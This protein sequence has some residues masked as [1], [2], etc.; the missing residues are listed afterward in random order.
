[1]HKEVTSDSSLHE[2]LSAVDSLRAFLALLGFPLHA[3]FFM[4]GS[5]FSLHAVSDGN[6][7]QYAQGMLGLTKGYFL[8]VCYIHVFRMATFFLLT[9]FFARLIYQKYGRKKF[10]LNRLYRIGLP[11]LFFQLWAVCLYFI[12]FSLA[13]FLP[14]F[15]S[16]VVSNYFTQLYVIGGG[17]WGRVNSLN[18]A[19]F[20]YF[21]LWFYA[22]T[23][24]ILRLRQSSRRFSYFL[25]KMDGY[26]LTLFS[27]PWHCMTIG[28]FCGALLCFQTKV[29]TIAGKI[30]LLPQTGLISSYGVW[31][32]L[33]WWLWGHQDKFLLLFNRCRL[34][35]FLSLVLYGASICWYLY[36][37]N[38]HYFF[39]GIIDVLLYQLSQSYAVMA[40][41]GIAWHYVSKPNR[42]LRYIS[43]ASYWLYVVQVP[44]GIVLMPLMIFFD[45]DYIHNHFI[46]F[47]IE[48][49]VICFV[50]ALLS[51]HLL[52]RHTWLKSIFGGKIHS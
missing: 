27:S 47:S 43:G 2:R 33:G 14:D 19:W 50:I 41:F 10:I 45:I 15:F 8:S 1:M 51:Y 9:G 37:A 24:L 13:P 35:L 44:V 29:D 3:V 42:L 22:L 6:W 7:V 17:W 4:A 31:Y 38:T 49:S 40:L 12:F 26:C 34:K 20:L 36:S 52:V 32:I 46:S 11:L 5:F 18:F 48:T 25:K 21:L 39:K 30:T 28:L 23:F 16:E